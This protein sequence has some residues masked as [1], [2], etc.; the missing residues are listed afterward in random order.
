[1]RFS[2]AKK[3]S[4][5]QREL[6]LQFMLEH[7]D[8]AR[9]R[10]SGPQAGLRK[11]EL[12][13]ELTDL[14]NSCPTGGSKTPEKWSRSWMDWRSDTKQKAMKIR[15]SAQQTGGG[16]STVVPLTAL[17]E[18][19]IAFIGETAVSGI[20]GIVDPL[21]IV[22]VMPDGSLPFF[23]EEGEASTSASTVDGSTPSTSGMPPSAKRRRI[24]DADLDEKEERAL[25]ASEAMA[26][27]IQRI[28]SAVE[29]VAR[30]SEETRR[31]LEVLTASVTEMKE[32]IKQHLRK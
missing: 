1:M 8:L 13:R 15:R 22:T 23:V 12:W 4:L 21:E 17:E 10:I 16:P 31:T 26:D 7:L 9:G 27:A 20:P 29:V 28:A 30:N 11:S 14:L 18:K 25:A 2:G 32:M 24:C 3:I 19:L 6:M 5:Y